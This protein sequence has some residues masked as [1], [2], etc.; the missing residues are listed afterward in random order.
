[1]SEAETEKRRSSSWKK[2]K[3]ILGILVLVFAAVYV[4]ARL[5]AVRFTNRG[6]ELYNAGN[7]DEAV[8]QYER[9]MKV[10]PCFKP[11]RMQLG[12]ICNERAESAF[13]ENEYA[14]AD[15]LYKKAMKLG[16]ELPDIHYRLAQVC[17][18][19]GKNAEGLAELEEHLKVEPKDGRAL[20]LRR[21]LQGGKKPKSPP[22]DTPPPADDKPQTPEKTNPPAESDSTPENEPAP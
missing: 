19:Q 11:A 17:W 20:T 12:R 3:L 21:V 22:E 13:N 2:V 9:A 16:V 6:T 7:F 14:E 5:L 18:G 10:Y 1:M 15:K 8:V 4:P